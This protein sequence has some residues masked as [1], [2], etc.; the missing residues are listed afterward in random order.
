MKT[1]E[2]ATTGER[3]L[4]HRDG[5]AL[6]KLQGGGLTIELLS[7]G[8]IHAITCGDIIVNQ[9]LAH[10]L[11]G[12]MNRLV[13]RA[14]DGS[15]IR[16]IQLI[17]P[18]S[19]SQFGTDGHGARW[20]GEWDGLA[21]DVSLRVHPDEPIW[22]WTVSVRNN[23][24][25]ARRVD[26]LCGQDIGLSAAAS[27]RSN[28][29]YTSHYIDHRVEKD[30]AIGPVILSRQ[31]NEQG[32]AFPWTMCGCLTGAE[33]FATD[34]FQFFGLE[35]KITGEPEAF[36]R[37]ALPSKKL[38]Y[39]FAYPSLQAQP[40]DLAPGASRDIE[41]FTLVDPNH[42]AASSADDLLK[43]ADVKKLR[44]ALAAPSAATAAV[45][46]P[47][48]YQAPL[49][50]S[51][52]LTD[53]EITEWF[54][55]DRRCAERDGTSLLSFFCGADAHVVLKA[56]ERASE[57]PHGHILRTGTSLLPDDAT[58]SAT[59]YMFGVFLS[60]VTVGNTSFHKLLSVSRS[61]LNVIRT[62][63]QRVFVQAKDGWRMLGVAS[64]FEMRPGLCRWMYKASDAL[65]EVRAAASSHASALRV[66]I[67][68]LRGGPR[69]FVIANDVVAGNNE[70]DEPARMT[71]D[72]AGSR[73]LI[74][75]VPDSFAAKHYPGLSFS[76]ACVTPGAMD[77][78]GGAELVG[79]GLDQ[80]NVPIAVLRTKPIAAVTLRIRGSL[81][82]GA[83]PAQEPV[84]SGMCTCADDITDFVRNTTAALSFPGSADSRLA[85][86]Q[87]ILPWFAQ[88]A[89]IHCTVPHG[90]E[91]Y[92]G[93][94][95]GTRDVC[96][97][98][99]E[100]LL[101]FGHHKEVRRIIERVYAQ[102]YDE[103]A[104]W[105]QWFMFD[106]YRKIQHD[107]CHGDVIFWPLKSL[108]E[109]IETTSD[110]A[111]LDQRIPWTKNQG[112]G[113]TEETSTLFEHTQKQVERIRAMFIGGSAIVCYGDGDW[114]DTLQPADEKMRSRMAS[115]W[116]VALCYQVLTR[117]AEVCRRADRKDFSVKLDAMAADVRRDFNKIVVRDGIVSGFVIFEDNGTIRPLLHPD[118]K[119]T[120]IRYRLLPMT[121]GII[122][123]IFTPEQ[124]KKHLELIEKHLL[125]PDGARLMDRA[126][127]Y[128]DGLSKLFKRAETSAYFG[129]EVSLQYV[130]AHIRYAEALA[131]VGRGQELL[132]ALLTVNPVQVRE[133]VPSAVARQSNTYFSSSD[134]D[135]ADRY[136][137]FARYGEIRE[138]KVPLKGG[139]RVYSSGPGIY[140]KQFVAHFLG[141]REWFGHVV[142]D[143]VM[144]PSL[145]GLVVSLNFR[146]RAMKFRYHVKEGI[147]SPQKI[148]VGGKPLAFT[149]QANPYREGG[150]LIPQDAFDA[151]VQAGATVEVTL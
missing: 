138:G 58:M 50:E 107:H 37:A 59:C 19:P 15:R 47:T 42:A 140:L 35:H 122:S 52:D 113:V 73:I 20:Q 88:D 25:S 68:V 4:I 57:R 92:G 76:I 55:S 123:E 134:G 48:M 145:D 66:D 149:R 87:E 127:V 82:A 53:A 33:S 1:S 8:S 23:G 106:A 78:M 26:A 10:P 61:H 100:F 89:L 124:A 72:E 24:K 14:I 146:G 30:A 111:I 5:L 32:G 64:A 104:E 116:T 137:A 97:G 75:P 45:A 29:A 119:V 150:A 130:H 21:Y 144:D 133:T 121:R 98:P 54:G 91:Q 2:T 132:K 139:W 99:V 9:W 60:Q 71:V 120:G 108:C 84:P 105:P 7:N 110:F 46:A 6:H 86:M 117:Y 44:A 16:P 128:H 79:A 36:G 114:D 40:F 34:G 77:A 43:L 31:N 135:L 51:D 81:T 96:Q 101:T 13:L 83:F 74:Q 148:E 136:E 143:P 109:Y 93:A 141:I 22:F 28:E 85:R 12:G 129:R 27:L 94:A 38:Q 49:L 39:E 70:L 103:T 3:H 11:E 102:Q 142:I 95:W 112:F 125:F 90:L 151:A 147:F 18:S 118:D 65:I 80:Q 131:K 17:G 115:G 62:A 126:A 69:V 63:G 56:K 41:F 67:N